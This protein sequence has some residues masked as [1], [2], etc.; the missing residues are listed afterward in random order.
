MIELYNDDCIKIMN[1]LISEN[2]KI[3]AIIC[4]PP[5]GTVKG[6]QTDGWKNTDISWDEKIDTNKMFELCEQLLRQNGILILFSQEPYTSEL[7]TSATSNIEFAYPLIWL[8]N[9]FC[10][11]L[12][13]KKAPVS[14][15][16]DISVFYKKYDSECSNPLREYFKNVLQYI[17]IAKADIMKKLGHQKADHVFRTE[18]MQ[19]GL[20]SEEVYKEL[21]EQFN[22]VAMGN[23]K[24]YQELKEIDS[25]HNT[26]TFNLSNNQKYKS[27]ILKYDKETFK[28][29]KGFSGNLY[30]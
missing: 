10:N 3:D 4:D 18:T 5:Y 15:F 27:N 9:H 7:R 28:F 11:Y 6:L 22:L 20:C 26:R 17:G 29:I 1:Q 2:K 8:K 19:F 21:T 25:K 16:E 14:Y 13:C 23:Y 30:K 24:T 12:T